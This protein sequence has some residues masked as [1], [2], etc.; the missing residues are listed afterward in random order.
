M[1]AGSLVRLTQNE[2][3]N[4]LT[5]LSSRPTPCVLPNALTEVGRP[6]CVPDKYKPLRGRKQAKG[7]FAFV[8][9][10]S[11]SNPLAFPVDPDDFASREKETWGAHA[12]VPSCISAN[13]SHA[14][15]AYCDRLLNLVQTARTPASSLDIEIGPY[16]TLSTE[17]DTGSR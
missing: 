12:D 17:V 15:R 10:I 8:I 9:Q 5:F 1:L 3:F 11:I 16:R 14:G 7:R 6:S 2:N 13:E 4:I